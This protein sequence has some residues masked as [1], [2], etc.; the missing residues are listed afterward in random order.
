MGKQEKLRLA[1]QTGLTEKKVDYWCAKQLVAYLCES[2]IVS[3]KMH[4]F[5]QALGQAKG[6]EKRRLD[7]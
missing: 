2:S 5:V 3:G 1:E 4:L 6:A 7:W